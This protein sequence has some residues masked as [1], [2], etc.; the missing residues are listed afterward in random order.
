MVCAR[1]L[2][3]CS[4]AQLFVI[5]WTKALQARILEW[6]AMPSSRGSSRPKD[7]THIFSAPALVGGAFTSEPPGK[8]H[9]PQWLCQFP[10]LPMAHR[11][12]LFSTSWP[13]TCYHRHLRLPLRFG[14]R[15]QGPCRVGTGESGLVFSGGW[16]AV[17]IILI[18]YIRIQGGTISKEFAY[19][20]RR[21]H[22]FLGQQ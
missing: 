3:C 12:S 2:S 11:N 21:H 4:H 10:F 15:P 14:L 13:V 19:Q 20:C 1:V 6:V 9:F 18:P 7:R 5:P 16:M 17:S 8:P 22:L